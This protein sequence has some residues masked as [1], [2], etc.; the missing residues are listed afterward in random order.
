MLISC[1]VDKLLGIKS[2][3]YCTLLFQIPSDIRD[4][5]VKTAGPQ[6][7]RRIDSTYINSNWCLSRRIDSTYINSKLVPISFGQAQIN[8]SVDKIYQL[9]VTVLYYI[10][11]LVEF[12][13]LLSFLTRQTSLKVTFFSFVVSSIPSFMFYAVDHNPPPILSTP[14]LCRV[15]FRVAASC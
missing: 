2:K 12:L 3:S 9:Y 8:L 5:K 6:T 7:E 14:R 11:V 15:D 4:R 13:V 10:N 1:I